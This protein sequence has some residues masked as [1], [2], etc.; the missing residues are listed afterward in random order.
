MSPY[1]AVSTTASSSA[2]SAS[3][4]SLGGDIAPSTDPRLLAVI[5]V[6]GIVAAFLITFI[7][8]ITL[9]VKRREVNGETLDPPHGTVIHQDHPAAHITP[10]G[11][12]GAQ[13]GGRVPRFC[14]Y[15]VILQLFFFADGLT[16]RTHPGRTCASRSA[17][18]TA[19]GTLPTPA[20]RSPPPGYQKST[21][22]PHQFPRLPLGASHHSPPPACP[23]QRNKKRAIRTTTTR[24]I[25]HHRHTTESRVTTTLTTRASLHG[26]FYR[27][28]L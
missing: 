26:Q 25:R 10:F 14:E 1:P 20:L 19:H 9:R 8:Y 18:P 15:F 3:A 2:T 17:A 12:V 23:V 6:L 5:I 24:T 28:Y 21:S 22:Y 4:T 7:V 16:Q 27:L 13:Y 11:A